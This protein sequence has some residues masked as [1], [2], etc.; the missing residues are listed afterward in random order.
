MELAE[1]VLLVRIRAPM[2]TRGLIET[3]NNLSM[4]ELALVSRRVREV[5]DDVLAMDQ[6]EIAAILDQSLECLASGDLKMFRKRINTAVSRLGHLK[7][8]ESE[9]VR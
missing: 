7:L 8:H 5:R 6:T 2:Q 9:T 4:G 1:E 3:L